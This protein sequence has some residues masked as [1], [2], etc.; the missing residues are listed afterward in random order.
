MKVPVCCSSA[1]HFGQ[2]KVPAQQSSDRQ[3]SS[4]EA[5]RNGSWWRCVTLPLK[6]KGINL[7]QPSGDLSFFIIPVSNS[8]FADK[9]LSLY[10]K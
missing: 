7:K 2:P 5:A 9:P 10:L 1:L 3:Q 6:N 4:R 8:E